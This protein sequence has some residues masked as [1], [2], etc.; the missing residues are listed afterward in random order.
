MELPHWLL[1]SLVSSLSCIC[2]GFMVPILSLFVKNKQN[3]INSKLVNYGLSLS[4]GSMITTAL[5]KLVPQSTTERSSNVMVF[6]GVFSGIFI[7]IILNWFI[8]IYASESLIHC[9]DEGAVI[10]HKHGNHSH[11]HSDNSNVE[12]NEHTPL[13]A[14]GAISSHSNSN[15]HSAASH[16][17]IPCVENHISYDLENINVYRN[18][19]IQNGT[20]K[21]KSSSGDV[22]RAILASHS[23]SHSIPSIEHEPLQMNHVQDH[24]HHIETPFSKLFS[25]GLQTCLVM[26]LHKFPEGFIIFYTNQG[27]DSDTSSTGFSIFISLAIH[28]FIEGFAMTLPFYTAFETKIYAVL[29]TAVLGGGSQPLGAILGYLMFGNNKDP[30]DDEGNNF[31]T[32]L[33]SLTGG[34]LLL[35]GFQMFQTG[36]GFSDIHHHH[37]HH[38]E[39]GDFILDDA[40]D[41]SDVEVKRDD[42]D[43]HTTSLICIRWCCTGVI[44]IFLS[45]ALI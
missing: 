27:N 7:G 6:L 29:I 32:Y 16:V 34:F 11:S 42:L 33:L 4:A 12:S 13:V 44:I 17:D 10:D 30:Q 8:H 24:L 31:M 28:N 22:N 36:I 20:L 3:Q 40:D 18:N 41:I 45:N 23:H 39:H 9:V 19:F 14:S 35:I 15:Y 5:Y 43:D 26:T 21:L 25:I 2:G 37:N 38:S 1:F